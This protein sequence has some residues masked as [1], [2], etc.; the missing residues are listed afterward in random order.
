MDVTHK[1]RSF[2]KK[3]FIVRFVSFFSNW[4][5]R[6][7][8]FKGVIAVSAREKFK[9]KKLTSDHS[10]MPFQ[11]GLHK[12]CTDAQI[13]AGRLGQSRRKARFKTTRHMS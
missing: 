10:E 8:Y 3:K 6:F 2:Y 13:C 5:N 11:A 4:E 7:S 12:S 9:R 1:I